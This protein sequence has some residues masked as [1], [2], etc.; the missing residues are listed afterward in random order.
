VDTDTVRI[1]YADPC[2]Y[3][4]TEAAGTLDHIVPLHAGGKHSSGNL[5]ACCRRCNAAKRE[6]SLLLFLLSREWR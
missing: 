4:G 6:K 3:C 2:A 1:L 5:T